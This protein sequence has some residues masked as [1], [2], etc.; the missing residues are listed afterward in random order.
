MVAM[1]HKDTAR[2]K[3]PA[4]I[5]P[6]VLLLACVSLFVA[7][8]AQ[9]EDASKGAVATIRVG[10]HTDHVRIVFEAAESYV[11]KAS[12]IV[13]GDNS[14]KVDFQAPVVFRVFQKGGHKAHS[15]EV[16]ELPRSKTP[17]D[18]GDGVRVAAGETGCVIVISNLDDI[19]VSKLFSPARLVINAF[20]DTTAPPPE[21]HPEKSSGDTA[22]ETLPVPPD[23][24]DVKVSSFMLDAGHGGYDSGIRAH[25]KSEKDLT[26][27]FAKELANTLGKKGKK[28]FITRKGDHTMSLRERARVTNRKS[29]DIFLSIHVSSANEFAIYSAQ[30]RPGPQ[31]DPVP[32]AADKDASGMLAQSLA[33]YVRSEFKMNVRSEKLPLQVLSSVSGPAVLIELPNPEKFNYDAKARERLVNAIMKGIAYSASMS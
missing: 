7:A 29:P 25:N 5:L 13:A 6:V 30:R 16:K 10:K 31:K 18:I 11:Q 20:I 3:R 27:Q 14:I 28:V 19:S 23:I 15:K 26:L 33:Q 32:G 22:Q 4:G 1:E 21:A 17:V 2:P 9:G 12:V 24:A 8:P